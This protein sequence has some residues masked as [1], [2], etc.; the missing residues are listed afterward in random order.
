LSV[1]RVV[2]IDDCEPT[3][4]IADEEDRIM[5]DRATVEKLG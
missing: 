3:S 4:Y 2:Y 5:I 1:E